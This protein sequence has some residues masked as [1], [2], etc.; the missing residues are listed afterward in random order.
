MVLVVVV[1]YAVGSLDSL[2]GQGSEESDA[3]DALS[4][5]QDL[6]LVT[7]G[8]SAGSEDDPLIGKAEYFAGLGWTVLASPQA[9]HMMV[10]RCAETAGFLKVAAARSVAP[11]DLETG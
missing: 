6:E 4:G 1:L 7:P 2:G 8:A 10:L 9:A 3:A 5:Y 11:V